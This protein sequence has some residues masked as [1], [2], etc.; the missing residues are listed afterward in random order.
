MINGK[1]V[2]EN[3][4]KELMMY[5]PLVNGF[6]IYA[7]LFSI[8]DLTD[9]VKKWI[10][11]NFIQLRYLTDD[12]VVFFENYRNVLYECPNVT[13]NR[14]SRNILKSKWQNNIIDLIK[15]MINSS[16]YILLYVDRFFISE[17]NFDHS[18]MHELFIYGYDDVEDI[19][20]CADNLET[21]KYKK[22][23]CSFDEFEKAYWNL[24]DSSYYTDIHC[25]TTEFGS[26]MADDLN[27]KQICKLLKDYANSD[28]TVT[29]GERFKI[30]TYGFQI[31]N[32]INKKL[33]EMVENKK[34]DIRPL[35]TIYEH[36][37]LMIFR[38]QYLKEYCKN[39]SFDDLIQTYIDIKDKYEV[40]LR[41]VQKYNITYAPN[42]IGRIVNIFGSAI[43]IEQNILPS[44]LTIIDELINTK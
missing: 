11:N 16:Y 44:L 39:D 35:Y 24:L 41:L 18:S 29:F 3:M 34:I 21:G 20:L 4:K 33:K 32:E 43:S 37:V 6:N 2:I 27:L 15:E 31:H 17:F 7:S 8:L 22:F 30:R 10:S 5:E 40:A 36:K 9:D 14:I 38:L 26:D 19:L 23:Q 25:I 1:E 13:V 28:T 12:N 42:I